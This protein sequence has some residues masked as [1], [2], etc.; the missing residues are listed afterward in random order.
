MKRVNLLLCCMLVLLWSMAVQGAPPMQAEFGLYKSTASAEKD[1][2]TYI[3]ANEL[4]MFVTNQGS[5]AYDNGAIFGKADGLYFPRGT[6]L[7]VIYAGGL[8]LG[9]K[10]GGDLRVSLAEYS[11]TYIPG[12]M[13]GGT[14]MEDRDEF[15][16]YKII[17]DLRDQGFYDA[18]RPE[19]PDSMIE[20]WNDYHSWPSDMGAPLD[21]EGNPK[22][23]GDQTLWCVYND[24]DPS[25]HVNSAGSSEGLGIE[26]Q[27]TTFAF[28]RTG[29]LGQCLFI[30]FRFINKSGETIEEMYTSVWAD[31]DLG[32]A[33]D[34]FVGCDT[35][36]SL[37]YCYN[38]T[39]NDANYGSTPPA[40]GYDF[41]QGPVV[42]GEETDSVFFLDK[43]V[44]GIKALPMT[45]FAK[46]INGTD[47][48]NKNET[49]WYMQ[50]LDAKNSGE[51]MKDNNEVET[52]YMLAGDP[53]KG[54]GWNDDN[55]SDR[56]Y[57]QSTGPFTMEPNDTQQVVVAVL[58][59]QGSDRLTSITALKFNDLFAQSAF[60][61]QFDLPNP[62][63]RPLVT[64]TPG[65]GSIVL[66]WDDASELEP[67]DYEFQGYNIYQ[68][69]SIAGP[70]KRV[71]TFD[72]DDGTGIIFDLE[73]VVDDGAVI[74][75]PV[76]FGS[77]SGIRRFIELTQDAWKGGPL[78]NAMDYYWAVTAYSYNPDETP[79]TL[80]NAPAAITMAPQ[81]SAGGYLYSH[82]Y[83]D[84]VA[85]ADHPT[86]PG[87]GQV[88]VLAVDP[89][90][91]TGHDYVVSFTDTLIGDEG[92]KELIAAADMYWHLY[93]VTAE[94]YVLKNQINQVG[95]DDY[96]V[97]DGFLC[98]TM[99]PLFN[100]GAI[101]EV[102]T[103]D[104]PLAEPDN[105][106]Y[107]LNST[108]DWYVNSDHSGDFSRMNWQGLIGT[109]DW[110]IRFTA[111]GSEY[112]DFS[113]EVLW[114]HRAP[115][116]F[117]NIGDG[118][119]DDTSDDVRIQISCLDDDE[120]G[121]W[122]MGD[123]IYPTEQEYFEGQPEVMDYTWPDDFRIGRIIIVDYAEDTTRV[124][125]TEG[126]IIRFR[127]FKINKPV[128]TYTFSTPSV[129]A[130]DMAA[131]TEY[132]M[133]NIKVVPNPYFN[134]SLYELD[135]FDR[136]VRFTNLP[137]EC[138]I[139]IFNLAGDHVVTLEKEA[140]DDSYLVW[141]M[142]TKHGLPLASGLYIYIVTAPDGGE[143][144]SK[145]A[146]FTEVEQLNTF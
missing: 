142:L 72:I 91:F 78:H 41:F 15:K 56:R 50:G 34:D 103:A 88:I 36:L 55:P 2:Q 12:P 111:G 97:S 5:F 118:T 137:Y 35:S 61:A 13:S 130:A 145:M 31:P 141:S 134:Q 123:R 113:P 144:V 3:D 32:D 100:V 62:P 67:G 114:D 136:Q 37:G 132:D 75:H 128:D 30:D 117:W 86:G 48:D 89:T 95:D 17:K 119:P 69:E 26:V 46:Y 20:L 138:T 120:S 52:K 71:T 11:H 73:F 94:N 80:E 14:F 68:G 57:M 76:Q 25:V 131:D 104:G 92:E 21:D 83:G 44:H 98:K 63:S 58:A 19:A 105:V 82:D 6:K 79:K 10:I 9:G 99:G 1:F 101:E 129:V 4:L 18:V 143:F 146:V 110:E 135:Q 64:A 65:D 108:G 125:P 70:W 127:T 106:M 59:G 74:N 81:Q 116:E 87:D 33:G 85:I 42:E 121:G 84:T 45:S 96:A 133:S 16:V 126:T 47:P 29:A 93:D 77:D 53:V 24:A 8:W 115:F 66:H 28:N 22:I 23:I 124:Y 140:S 39:N 122:S 7:S 112:Y 51:P 102:A 60:D 40:T 38:A 109:D 90:E 43:W 107:S 139:K 49:Y 54:T 27:Q